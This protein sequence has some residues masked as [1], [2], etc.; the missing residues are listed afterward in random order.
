MI[1]GTAG[2]IDHGKTALVRALTGIDTDRLPEEKRRGITIDL[3]FAPLELEG[4]GTVGVVDVPGHEAFVR[5]MVAGAT[6][7]DVALLVVAADEGVMPQ[8]REHVRILSLLGVTNLVVAL[9]K[10]DLVAEDWLALAHEDVRMLLDSAGC[11]TSP[12]V[13]VSSLTGHGI[14]ALRRALSERLHGIP[15]RG[16]TGLFRLPIDRA[17]T[18]R[19]TGTVVTGTVWSGRLAHDAVVRILPADRAARV[20]GLHAHGVSV[21]AIDAGMRAAIAL[22]AVDVGEVPRGSVLVTDDAWEATRLLRAEVTLSDGVEATLRPRSRVRFHSG[23]AEV[24]ARVLLSAGESSDGARSAR[25][26]LDAPV[27]LRAGDRF[28]LRAA[29]PLDTIGGGVV[30][31]P[32]PPGRP[33]AWPVGADHRERLRRILQE[34][35]PAGADVRRLPIRLGLDQSGVD[36]LVDTLRDGWLRVGGRAWPAVVS[37]Q[38]RD[39]VRG[40][41]AE[42]HLRHP[43]EPG[44]PMH[45]LRQALRFPSELVDTL[46]AGMTVE[47]TG[48]LALTDGCLRQSGWS[49]SLPPADASLADRLLAE[50]RSAGRQPPSVGALA[51]RF[52]EPVPAVLRFL[53]RQGS[54]V[55]V[56][57]GRYFESGALNAILAD[58]GGAMEP[59]RSYSPAELRDAIGLSRKYLIPLLE[60]CD[61]EGYTVQSGAGRAWRQG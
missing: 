47:E 8:T 44:L 37:D 35:G 13:A 43:L 11:G 55:Q 50:L 12:I 27:V 14:P 49:P 45:A 48:G 57:A 30:T 46:V 7:I 33:K 31:D 3:G 23:T 5:S 20:R 60:F 58:I 61:R 53:E 19:G 4:V 52:G 34:A 41:V 39:A 2:H 38:L 36:A 54:V 1:L 56:E 6:G 10:S 32:L 59:G 18:I 24:G 29:A 28:V 9:T 17:F 25:L 26:S 22:A 15:R 40:L 16:A 42:H 51:E 21:Q